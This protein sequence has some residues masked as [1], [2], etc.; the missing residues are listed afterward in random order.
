MGQY[1]I[2]R[3]LTSIPLL[4]GISVLGFVI[5]HLAP[6]GPMA[7]YAFAPN[8][9]VKQLERIE[10][11][12]GLKEPLHIQYLKWLR[13]LI[14]GQWGYSYRDGRPV[15][16]VILERVPN[17]IQ[18]TLASF[19]IALCVAIP[20]GI[21]TATRAGSIIRYATNALAMTAV[22]IPTF[23]LGL[24]VILF[25]AGRLRL[26][27]SGGMYTIGAPFSLLDRLRH[28][29][30]PALVLAT[31]RIAEWLRF[32]HSSMVEVMLE[33]Y[34][35]TARAKGLRA[36]VILYR[37]A[38]RN[39]MIVLVTLLGLSLPSL[40]SG[41]LITEVVFSWPGNGRLLVESMLRR[42]YPVVMGNLM[43]IALL[44]VVG[45]LFADVAY[46]FLDPRVRYK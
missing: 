14:S 12:F 20:A 31:P 29:I 21:L 23:W 5:L 38:L 8:V 33:D 40:V 24:M 3:L 34:I 9:D 25:F 4:L 26:V 6:G 42:D 15:T 17:T 36:R 30:A 10:E 1:L 22:S 19:V 41:A 45:N 46:G 2:R 28:L 43:I 44:V 37:H 11:M 16:V 32:T 27:P 18:L 39:V 7:V 13:G 35:R